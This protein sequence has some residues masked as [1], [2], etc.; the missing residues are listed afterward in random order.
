MIGFQ[1]QI[2]VVNYLLIIYK[3]EGTYNNNVFEESVQEE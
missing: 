1:A 3:N 2:N